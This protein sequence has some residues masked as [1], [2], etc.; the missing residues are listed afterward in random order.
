M[1]I[2]AVVNRKFSKPAAYFWLLRPNR[3]FIVAAV[4]GSGAF[5][6]GVGLVQALWMTLAGWWLAVGG[7]S[8]DF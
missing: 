3:S 4:T 5:A 6:A 8:L 7:F 2:M 1:D